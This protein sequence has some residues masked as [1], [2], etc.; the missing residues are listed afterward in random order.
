MSP[1]VSSAAITR[2]A[3]A[4]SATAPAVPRLEVVEFGDFIF[5]LAELWGLV[6]DDI[7]QHWVFGLFGAGL[8]ERA[9]EVGAIIRVC[10]L[11]GYMCVCACWHNAEYVYLLQQ[12]LT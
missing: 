12:K 2:Y 5:L 3:A 6:V 8:G 7:R 11:C 10:M 4:T 1:T 9:R